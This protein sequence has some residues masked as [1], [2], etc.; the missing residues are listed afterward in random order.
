MMICGIGFLFH[1]CKKKKDPIK[2]KHGLF[3]EN[4][5][6]LYEL[7][8]NLDNTGLSEYLI[9]GNI[10]TVSPS[11][12]GGF[13]LEQGSI[14]YVFDQTTGDFR[15]AFGLTNDVFIKNLTDRAVRQTV[16]SGAY[17]FFCK[18]DGFEYFIISSGNGGNLDF[19]YLKNLPMYSANYPEIQGPFPI[20]LLNTAAN[21]AYLSFNNNFDT[22]YFSSD[23][24]GNY[25][26]YTQSFLPEKSLSDQFEQPFVTS[27]Q[28]DSINSVA[29]DMCPSVHKNVMVFASDRFGGLGGFDLYYSVLRKG[30]WSAP[31]NFGPEINTEYDEFNPILGSVTDFKNSYLIF[32][33]NRKGKD[34]LYFTGIYLPK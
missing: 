21:D 33:S 8:S 10:A 5:V 17:R 27:V 11:S 23:R 2:Y 19:F 25:D 1:S 34:E 32:S 3:P 18:I 9:Q 7:N 4:L 29:D 28:T 13:D 20:T 12:G 24:G 30:K 16:N 26:I 31:I 22:A 15:L 6:N 14:G